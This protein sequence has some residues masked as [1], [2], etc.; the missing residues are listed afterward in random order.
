[1]SYFKYVK[2]LNQYGTRPL[3]PGSGKNQL[4]GFKTLLKLYIRL[5]IDGEGLQTF[6][7]LPHKFDVA[8]NIVARD[9]SIT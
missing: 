7:N 9:I 3:P 4:L 8:W 2:L 6:T 5:E 1:M